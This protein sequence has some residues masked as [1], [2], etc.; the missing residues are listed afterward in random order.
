M[1]TTTHIRKCPY[2]DHDLLPEGVSLGDGLGQWEFDLP[3]DTYIK[4]MIVNGCKSYA[5][6]LS[7]GKEVVKQKGITLDYN[8]SKLFTFNSFKALVMLNDT[9]ESHTRYRF[10]TT[11]ERKVY[12]VHESKNIKFTLDQKRL[13]NRD[14]FETLR[15]GFELDEDF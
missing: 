15:F 10:K 6:K 7:N 2:R 9:I 4:E 11:H 1:T 13:Y 8:N 14:T 12:T 3:K 5:Y